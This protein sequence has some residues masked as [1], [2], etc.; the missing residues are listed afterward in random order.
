MTINLTIA[1][2]DAADLK[3]QLRELLGDD[4]ERA[5]T[6]SSDRTAEGIKALA[7]GSLA[8]AREATEAR[9]KEGVKKA[10]LNDTFKVP[11]PDGAAMAVTKHPVVS[12]AEEVNLSEAAIETIE[13]ETDGPWVGLLDVTPEEDTRVS[14]VY[15]TTIKPAVLR[16]SQKH[17]REG[18]LKLL[19]PYNVPNASKI[20]AGHYGALMAE[21]NRLLAD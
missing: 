19:E 9:I 18:V 12:T 3:R 17:N 16:V 6:S 10:A 1:A 5:F 4:T 13:I 8:S 11:E 20:T 15:N 14:E 21:I 2:A 7:S